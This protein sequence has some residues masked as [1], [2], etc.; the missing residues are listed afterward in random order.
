[1]WLR[2]FLAIL[3]CLVCAASSHAEEWNRFRGPNGSGVSDAIAIPESW[4]ADDYRWHV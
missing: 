1:M 2:V 3:L 4:T